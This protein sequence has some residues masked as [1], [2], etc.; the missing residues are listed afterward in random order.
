MQFSGLSLSLLKNIN[1]LTF[2]PWKSN[3]ILIRF[4]HILAKDEDDKY[5]QS[6]TF[7]LQDV[8]RSFDIASI[9]ETTLSANQWLDKAERLQFRTIANDSNEIPAS[10]TVSSSEVSDQTTIDQKIN[11][12]S[13]IPGRQYFESSR[14]G[15]F[16]RHRAAENEGSNFIITLNPMEIRTFVLELA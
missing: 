12:K 2:E 4:E 6:V 11:I 13:E 5:S 16:K 15:K 3:S 14:N 7:N 1:L 10:S 8:F 9:K